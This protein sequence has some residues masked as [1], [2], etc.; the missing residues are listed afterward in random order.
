MGYRSDVVI[1][2]KR[3]DFDRLKETFLKNTEKEYTKLEEEYKKFK[4]DSVYN[5]M[6]EVTIWHEKKADQKENDIIVF[7][8]NGIK[9]YEEYFDVRFILNFLNKLEEENAPY[10]LIVMGED[11]YT[12]EAENYDCDDDSCDIIYAQ[13]NIEIDKD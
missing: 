9:W 11:G 7:G 1:S 13:H 3:K 8:W 6:K 5:L 2:L 12:E 10:K 4:H